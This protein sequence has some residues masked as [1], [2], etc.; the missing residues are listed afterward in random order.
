MK[1]L[2]QLHQNWGSNSWDIPDMDKCSQNKC[3]LDK[4]H[5]DSWLTEP[6]ES[7]ECMCKIPSMSISSL[8]VY[9][10]GCG[11]S[12]QVLGFSLSQAKQQKLGNTYQVLIFRIMYDYNN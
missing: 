3:C 2:L 10:C 12:R 5:S 8:K 4:C 1:L 6:G 11:V 7:S 9:G